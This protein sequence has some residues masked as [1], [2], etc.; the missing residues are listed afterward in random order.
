LAVNIDILSQNRPKIHPATA[1]APRSLH[2]ILLKPL[3]NN[4]NNNPEKVMQMVRG[5]KR[6]A[7]KKKIAIREKKRWSW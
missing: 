4:F 5:K 2:I 7:S 1:I 3:K 6:K